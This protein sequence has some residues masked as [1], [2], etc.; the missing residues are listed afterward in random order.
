M[1]NSLMTDDVLNLL[2]WRVVKRVVSGHFNRPDFH[3]SRGRDLGVWSTL[4]E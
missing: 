2:L 1:N 4:L 3:S